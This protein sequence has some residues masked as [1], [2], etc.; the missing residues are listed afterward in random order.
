MEN[1]RET[2][3][4]LIYL[5]IGFI[6]TFLV[7]KITI[8]IAQITEQSFVVNLINSI[9]GIFDSPFRNIIEIKNP[10]LSA[11]NTAALIGVGVYS[12]TGFLLAKIITGFLYDNLEDIVQNFVDG[13]FKIFEFIVILRILFEL[14]AVLPATRSSEFVTTIFGLSE[15]TQS[16]L[17]RLPFGD[18]YINLSAIIWLL[19]LIFF[20]VISERY[21]A[22]LLGSTAVIATASG[23]ALP[24][25]KLSK[26]FRKNVDESEVSTVIVEKS[27]KTKYVDVSKPINSN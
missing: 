22:K 17:F 8:D 15:W 10:A 23:S 9:S 1:L 4:N 6:N 21:L 3:R 7:L 12:V 13:L 11:I 20:D 24:K 26:F 19:V 14:F 2:I 5:A 27:T 18:G 25:F 16:L